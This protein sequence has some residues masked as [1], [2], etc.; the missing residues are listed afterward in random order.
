MTPTALHL[1]GRGGDR[2]LARATIAAQLAAGDAV[3]VVLLPG[4][5]SLEAPPA[6]RVVRVPDDLGWDALLDLVFAADR[7]VTW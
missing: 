7:V 2:G 1:C 3:T 5:G 6:V 4:A